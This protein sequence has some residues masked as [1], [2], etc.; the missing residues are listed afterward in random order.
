MVV[1]F[2]VG[3]KDDF[4]VIRN[5]RLLSRKRVNDRKTFVTQ[6]SIITCVNTAPV[7]TAMTNLLRHLKNLSTKLFL[8]TFINWLTATA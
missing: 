5:K 7:R 3:S 1:D 8:K 6:N 2:T 4:F